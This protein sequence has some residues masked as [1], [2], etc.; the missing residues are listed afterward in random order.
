MLVILSGVSASRSE[1]F[2]ESKDPY[3]A[4]AFRRRRREHHPSLASPITRAF[5]RTPAPQ[6][7]HK[8][9]Q[10]VSPGVAIPNMTESRRDD[11]TSRPKPVHSHD[12]ISVTNDPN[13]PDDPGT[14]TNWLMPPASD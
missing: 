11:T 1:A 10:G 5:S 6:G 4:N 2:T 13:R 12:V 3:P 14:S 9:A 8:L 7:R